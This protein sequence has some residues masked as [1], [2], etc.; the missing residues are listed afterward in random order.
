M[1]NSGLDATLFYNRSTYE[2][3]NDFRGYR[4]E[5][6]S[7]QFA[8]MTKNESKGACSA[9]RSDICVKR[10]IEFQKDNQTHLLLVKI[11]N[12]TVNDSGMYVVW[13]RFSS[14]EKLHPNEK[15]AK[16]LKVIHVKVEGDVCSNFPETVT[17]NSGLDAALFYNISTY[18]NGEHFRVYHAEKDSLQFA[19]MTKGESK[20]DCSGPHSDICVKRKIE[21]RKDN[22]MHLL[23]VKIFNTTVNDSGQ[24]SVWARF[25]STE[26]LHPNEK[27]AKCLKVIQVKVEDNFTETWTSSTPQSTQVYN[28]SSSSSSGPS[29]LQKNSHPFPS[30][31]TGLIVLVFIILIGI[32][33]VYFRNRQNKRKQKIFPSEIE[34]AP[35]QPPAQGPSSGGEMVVTSF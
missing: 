23:V 30:L 4:A 26:K 24:Y 35:T 25:S 17:V 19:H 20:G 21:F 15:T 18:E 5:K 22:Q 2:N 34:M 28:S 3:E 8:H 27:T 1:V 9:P 11:F 13:A 7:L 33:F 32:G 6:N 12:T 10:K 31:A 14:S 16:C 29:S